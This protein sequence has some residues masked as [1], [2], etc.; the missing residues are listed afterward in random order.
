LQ[1]GFQL[2]GTV[3]WV[4]NF[5][6]LYVLCIAWNDFVGDSL[7]HERSLVISSAG[8]DGIFLLRV[9]VAAAPTDALFIAASDM[10]EAV[11]ALIDRE[12]SSRS[13][14]IEDAAAADL[15]C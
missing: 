6:I 11:V 5:V 15:V 12:P 9:R 8:S 2:L 4:G 1:H 13:A 3:F 7:A 14:G 10:A